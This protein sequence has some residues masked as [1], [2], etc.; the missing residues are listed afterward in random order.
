M[1][2]IWYQHKNPAQYGVSCVTMKFGLKVFADGES[3][4]YFPQCMRVVYLPLERNQSATY[5]YFCSYYPFKEVNP[6]SWERKTAL[7]LNEQQ[8]L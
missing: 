7:T 1:L 5:N 4:S 3:K 8:S 2:Q 6:P